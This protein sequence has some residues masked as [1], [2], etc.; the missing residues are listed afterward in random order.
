MWYFIHLCHPMVTT[1][2]WLTW[3][4]IVYFRSFHVCIVLL[5]IRS[6]CCMAHKLLQA[7]N[8]E[9]AVHKNEHLPVF[10]MLMR[11][12]CQSPKNSFKQ[13]SNY[14]VAQSCLSYQIVHTNE[15]KSMVGDRSTIWGVSIFSQRNLAT[16]SAA[17][18]FTITECK[19]VLQ[20]FSISQS[21]ECAK[22]PVKF[23]GLLI[24]WL[25]YRPWWRMYS[26]STGMLAKTQ[27]SSLIPWH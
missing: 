23:V 21:H 2:N 13:M 26:F 9:Y 22:E 16:Q 17:C 27:S 3:Y 8:A 6:T 10:H 18:F 15:R 7:T 24:S 4:L 14:L 11:R 20:H 12:Q 19:Y 1:F 5:A 25:S